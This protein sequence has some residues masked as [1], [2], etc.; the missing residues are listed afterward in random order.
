[1]AIIIG[2]ARINEHGRTPGGKP[3]DQ[4]T[5]EVST[6]EFYIHTKGWDILRAKSDEVANKLA[7]AMNSACANQHIGY[8][9][10]HRGGAFNL[11]DKYGSLGAIAE[12]TETDCSMLVRACVKQATGVLV[13]DFTTGNE[14]AVL[15]AS[16]LFELKVYTNG[17]PLY[18][19]DI[20]VT[21]T[22]GH[23]AIV[24]SGANTRGGVKSQMPTIKIGS[25]GLAVKTWQ[26]IVGSYADGIFGKNTRSAT[27]IW[28][29]A[30]GLSADGIVGPKTWKAAGY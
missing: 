2:S 19:G 23:T 3:G 5:Y 10:T 6:Q 26:K 15:T 12:N 28:Q 18:N 11:L 29:K 20:L 17:T 16:G 22:K 30:H 27:I 14:A 8:C 4:T 7:T 1:M 21:R 9:Q 25:R 13:S 24:V